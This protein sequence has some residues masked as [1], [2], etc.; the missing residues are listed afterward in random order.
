MINKG[1]PCSCRKRMRKGQRGVEGSGG[2][3]NLSMACA[4]E[5]LGTT[6]KGTGRTWEPYRSGVITP[7]VF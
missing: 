2:R 5:G 1:G 6:G 7:Q 4:L 3:K